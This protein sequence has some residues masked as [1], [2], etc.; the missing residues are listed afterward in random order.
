VH[1][2]REPENPHDEF[3]I[4]VENG[5]FETVGHFPRRL[6]SWLASLIDAGKLRVDGYVPEKAEASAHRCNLI[7]TVFLV[8]KGF[9][10]Q[11]RTLSDGPQGF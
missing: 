8:E 5:Q 6:T 10:P 7:L 1:F 11:V 4:R 3:S 2:E 9:I